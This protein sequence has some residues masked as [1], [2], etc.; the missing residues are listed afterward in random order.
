MMQY[1]SAIALALL[2]TG[3]LGATAYAALR[4]VR[5]T[6]ELAGSEQRYRGLIDQMQDGLVRFD[7]DGVITLANP[8]AARIFGF[9]SV[10]DMLGRRAEPLWMSAAAWDQLYDRMLAAGTV[11]H[12]SFTGRHRDGSALALEGAIRPL[13]LASGDLL[14]AEAVLR[15]ASGPK[16]LL[17]AVAE[18]AEVEARAQA[19]HEATARVKAELEQALLEQNAVLE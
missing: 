12:E 18:V 10:R 17:A 3:L 8:S 5:A 4:V 16:R 11:L 13:R 15:D 9:A 14:G 1:T 7:P 19:A 2:S 6:R